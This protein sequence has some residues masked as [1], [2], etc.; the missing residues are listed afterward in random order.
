MQITY[1]IITAIVS[2]A[3]GYGISRAV[4]NAST[5]RLLNEKNAVEGEFANYRQRVESLTSAA[6]DA[7]AKFNEIGEFLAVIAKLN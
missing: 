6:P 3:A 5:V 4:S 7:I 2:L 1:I